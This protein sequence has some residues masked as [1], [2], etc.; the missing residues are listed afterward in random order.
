MEHVDSLQQHEKIAIE[1]SNHLS[2]V[3]SKDRRSNNQLCL[4]P[5][6]VK[7]FKPM[8]QTSRVAFCREEGTTE[9]SYN[10]PRRSRCRGITACDSWAEMPHHSS[11]T[12]HALRE[13]DF[14]FLPH[15]ALGC[16]HVT[17]VDS[18]LKLQKQISVILNRY[19]THICSEM[20]TFYYT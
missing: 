18:T 2:S 13:E 6:G 19:R 17:G 9:H 8:L 11:F 5:F 10:V 7:W 16:T 20:G 14:C 12:P 4:L 1:K 15:I 3:A